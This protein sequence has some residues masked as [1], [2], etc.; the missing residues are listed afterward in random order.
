[1]HA[2]SLH[3][4]VLDRQLQHH[5]NDW[6]TW[7]RLQSHQQTFNTE[8][9]FEE[10]KITRVHGVLADEDLFFFFLSVHFPAVFVFLTLFTA[11]FLFQKKKKVQLQLCRIVIAMVAENMLL[12]IVLGRV[13]V[14]LFCLYLFFY[15][16]VIL[17]KTTVSCSCHLYQFCYVCLST[18][19]NFNFCSSCKRKC[20]KQKRIL[21]LFISVY[22][23][24]FQNSFM[25][26][27]LPHMFANASRV[28]HK[29]SWLWLR[30]Y[31]RVLFFGQDLV[32][33]MFLFIY[34]LK[35]KYA[36]NFHQPF[37]CWVSK[38]LSFLYLFYV[39][40]FFTFRLILFVW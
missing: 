30:F 16:F 38:I 13:L 21:L 24:A 20:W 6:K 26:L 11:S 8:I 39:F 18:Y 15:F 34:S 23:C 40:L 33:S 2:L 14:Y 37:L 32:I 9:F 12:G 25:Y 35:K 29:V 4:G 28:W 22:Q 27:D 31:V 10:K 1:M 36:F 19:F 5:Q 17:S 3:F 7:N